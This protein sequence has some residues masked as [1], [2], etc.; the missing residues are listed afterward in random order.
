MKSTVE[1]QFSLF[2]MRE[3]FKFSEA[4]LF[5]A[6][7]QEGQPLCKRPAITY[8]P[9]WN[10]PEDNLLQ[11]SSFNIEIFLTLKQKKAVILF[12]SQPNRDFYFSSPPFSLATY[13][14]CVTSWDTGTFQV[15]TIHIVFQG[16]QV[17]T[18]DVN[19]SALQTIP[20]CVG[21]SGVPCSTK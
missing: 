14:G 13:S 6:A 18:L 20:V 7:A 19:A 17:C 2:F 12:S 21:G 5:S 3:I 9:Q 16:F 4:I 1:S 15:S 10:G 8:C 11:V